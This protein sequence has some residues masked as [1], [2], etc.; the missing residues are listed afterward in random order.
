MECADPPGFLRKGVGAPYQCP[1][2]TVA[3]YHIYAD[4]RTFR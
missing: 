1:F 4:V 2:G 3:S